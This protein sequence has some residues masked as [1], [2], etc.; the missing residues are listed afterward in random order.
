MLPSSG[1]FS[2]DG[3]PNVAD[4]LKALATT[5]ARVPPIFSTVTH[6]LRRD[7]SIDH[8]EVPRN[9]GYIECVYKSSESRLHSFLLFSRY[10]SIKLRRGRTSPIGSQAPRSF[11]GP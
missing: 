7:L 8:I 4:V 6:A 5:P 9:N 11:A 3:T 1:C 2:Y 10:H